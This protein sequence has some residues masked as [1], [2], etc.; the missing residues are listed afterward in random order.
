MA[1]HVLSLKCVWLFSLP[2]VFHPCPIVYLYLVDLTPVLPSLFARLWFLPCE[3]SSAYSSWVPWVLIL[4]C[5]LITESALSLICIVA[6][7][8]L[9]SNY[10][11][12]VN[13]MTIDLEHSPTLLALHYWIP[14]TC[15]LILSFRY[16]HD[17]EKKKTDGNTSKDC[18]YRQKNDLQKLITWTS[19]VF[20]TYQ[21]DKQ[22]TRI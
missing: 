19:I 1:C 21:H 10:A 20:E 6:T 2:N 16:G 12:I 7:F 15:S 18:V 9:L 4:F 17:P 11:T 22:C 13:K 14:Q 8:L 5:F 3:H